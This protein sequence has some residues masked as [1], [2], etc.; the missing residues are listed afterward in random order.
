MESGREA[1][2]VRLGVGMVRKHAL[3]ESL[4]DRPF[5]VAEARRKGVSPSRVRASDLVAPQRGVRI[6]IEAASFESRCHAMLAHHGDGL[7]FSHV[8]AARLYGAPLPRRMQDAAELHVTVP[9]GARAPQ[10]RGVRAH[11]IT[12]WTPADV[13]GLPVTDPAQTWLDLVPLLD[14]V[15]SIAVADYL[16]SGRDPWTTR[17][18]L[19]RLVE[20]SS[21]R[22][23]VKHARAQL[24]FVR[25]R[26]DSPG[27]TRLRL[28]IVDAGLPEPAVNLTL[29]DRGG[30]HV[31]RVDLAYPIEQIALE[32]E[33]DVHRVDRQVWMKDLHRRERVEDLGWRLVRATALDLQSP[34]PLLRRLRTLLARRE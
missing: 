15:S 19:E 11:T 24:P 6:P 18:R 9:A 30:E 8:T 2:A 13:A 26:V 25:E 21:G 5:L 34:A 4:D 33:G 10:I 12:R 17:D 31:A 7:V 32:Y 23:G 14:R 28:L 16:V 3:P 29:L 20:R 1:R 27:E 22:R